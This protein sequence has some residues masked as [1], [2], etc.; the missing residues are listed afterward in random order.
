MGKSKNTINTLG[1]HE[2]LILEH[3]RPFEDRDLYEQWMVVE[4]TG[5][6]AEYRHEFVKR[7]THLK[8]VAE[9]MMLGAFLRGLKEKVKA[10]L[11]R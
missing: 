7:L 6:V 3:F 11:R 5:T 8:Q 9:M 2:D 10:E 1:I 4:Q